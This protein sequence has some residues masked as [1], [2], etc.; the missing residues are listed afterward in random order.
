MTLSELDNP[1]KTL[2]LIEQVMDKWGFKET[3]KDH[4]RTVYDKKTKW[5]RF[6]NYIFKEGLEISQ[7][8]DQIILK[9][10]RNTFLNLESKLKKL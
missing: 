9:G 2:S 5:G 6:W 8:G 1:Q 10:R 7:E 3:R 4:E